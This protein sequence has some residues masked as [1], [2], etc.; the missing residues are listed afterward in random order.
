M[1]ASS[2]T[3]DSLATEP[4]ES[5]QSMETATVA[6]AILV[7]QTEE[8]GDEARHLTGGATYTI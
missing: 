8:E 3:T 4:P 2:G 1:V 6:S 5:T 7:D